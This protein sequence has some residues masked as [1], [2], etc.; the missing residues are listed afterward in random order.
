MKQPV[1]LARRFLAVAK[2]RFHR[3][4]RTVSTFVPFILSRDYAGIVL[5]RWRKT[6]YDSRPR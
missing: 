3:S 4:H 1:D 5:R 2:R 6:Y